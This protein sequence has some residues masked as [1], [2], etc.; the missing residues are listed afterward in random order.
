MARRTHDLGALAS[1]LS[2]EVVTESAGPD[3]AAML[4][5]AIELTD[6]LARRDETRPDWLCATA[7]NVGRALL[8]LGHREDAEHHLSIATDLA[9]R[10]VGKIQKHN[11]VLL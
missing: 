7:L 2:Q 11:V 8:R 3:A 4:R 6:V 1:A 5:A 9:Q 10:G